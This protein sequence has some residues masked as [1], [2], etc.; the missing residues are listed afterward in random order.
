[1]SALLLI[2]K[3]TCQSLIML[4]V[5]WPQSGLGCLFGWKEDSHPERGW[6]SVFW[7]VMGYV[8]LALRGGRL[9]VPSLPYPPC[10]ILP[11][12]V[13]GTSPAC[14]LILESPGNTL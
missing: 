2:P 14:L 3:A 7:V 9:Q 5:S 1:M 6:E 8:G 10:L 4:C 13:P 11:G 12:T